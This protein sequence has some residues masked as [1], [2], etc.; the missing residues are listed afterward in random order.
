MRRLLAI[1][2]VFLLA[3]LAVAGCSSAKPAASSSSSASA[4]PKA[5]SSV[6]VSGNFGA[7]P[8]VGI[9]KLAA[10]SKLFVKTE[11]SGTGA[12]VTKADAMAANFVL[13]FWDG[14]SSSLKANTFTENPTMIGGT[15]L[16]GLQAAL[17]GK[18]IGSRVLA[19]VPPADGYGTAGDSQLGISATT[20]LVFVIDLIKAYPQTATA[21]G[22]AVSDGGGSLP[23]V[24]AHAGGAPTITIPSS[25]PPSGLVTKTLIRGTGPKVAKGQYIITQYT[26]YIWRTK[27]VFDSSWTDGS[28]FGFVLD[29]NP[30]QVIAGWDAGL[31]GQTVGSRVMLVVPPKDGY[32]SSGQ[33]QAGISGT[34]TLV[35]VVDIIDALN[36]S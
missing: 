9:P 4:N 20:T 32:G 7:T 15:M 10:D 12:T 28:P 34:D 30:E 16:P 27:K 1:I 13:Y 33:S 22:P 17:I 35:Y 3:G 21:T 18:K 2:A 6:T 5:N 24:T 23:K 19:V 8:K 26:G 36:H 29:A 14:T 25:S 31:V 11:I